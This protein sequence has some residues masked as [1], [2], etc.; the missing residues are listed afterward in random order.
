LP[1]ETRYI[2]FDLS[3]VCSAVLNLRR[4]CGRP[5][6]AGEI[7]GSVIERD[8]AS[9]NIRFSMNVACSN[10]MLENVQVGQAE[11][12]TA[13]IHFC[14]QEKIPLPIRASK[15]VGIINGSIALICLKEKKDYLPLDDPFAALDST[16]AA[17]ETNAVAALGEGH[18]GSPCADESGTQRR[19][20][21]LEKIRLRL[22]E[23]AASDEIVS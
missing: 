15:L 16:M 2:C 3:E 13:L 17:R 1:T 9:G 14:R 12:G 11:I 20:A 10:G 22:R 6:P 21:R 5:S 4:R 18:P 23:K 8:E 19:R 7:V